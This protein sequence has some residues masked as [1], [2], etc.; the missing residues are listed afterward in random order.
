MAI[1]I[2]VKELK[3]ENIKIEELKIFISLNILDK[4]DI[5]KLKFDKNKIVNIIRKAKN[6]GKPTQIKPEDIKYILQKFKLEAAN[7]KASIG[8]ENP[9][10]TAILV[11]IISSILDIVFSRI[12]TNYKYS[13]NPIYKDKNYLF[14]SINCIFKIKLVHIISIIKKLKRKEYQENGKTSN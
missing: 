10:V 9:A 14:L 7:I 13:I 4:F 12:F 2:E 5:I 11:A 3:I 8:T 1:K 6:N